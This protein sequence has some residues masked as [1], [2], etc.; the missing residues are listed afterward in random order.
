MLESQFAIWC[1]RIL[2]AVGAILLFGV[3]VIVHEFGHFLAGRLLGFKV[4]A[5]SVGFGPAIWRK[6]IN[7]VVYRVGCIPLGGY[8]AL[9]QLDPSE[10]DV[11]Q[12]K[13]AEGERQPAPPVAPWKRIV[14][15]VAGPF[16]NIVLAVIAAFVIYAFSTPDNFGGVGVTVGHVEPGSPAEAAGLRIGDTFQTINGNGVSC[17][18]EVTIECILGGGTNAL[19]QARVMRVEGEKTVSVDL[20]LP[21]VVTDKDTGY[22]EIPGVE[23]RMKCLVG[24]VNPGSPAESAGIRKGDQLLAVNGVDLNGPEDLIDRVKAAGETPIALFLRR[25]RTGATETISLTPRFDA[26]AARPLIGIVFAQSEAA[27]QPWMMYRRPSLQ[28][29]NDAKGIFRILRALFAPRV[30]GEAKRAAKGMGGAVTLFVIFWMQ[31]QAGILQTLAFLRYLCINLAVI[32]LLPLPV[33]DGGHVMFALVE[34]VTRR[35]PSAKLTGWIYNIFA[36]LLIALML[37]LLL[38]DVWNFNRIFRRRRAAITEEVST[39]NGERGTEDNRQT[40]KPSNRQTGGGTGN[41]ERGTEDNRQ[42]VKPSNRQTGGGTGNGERGT[43]ENRQT[44]KP[45]NRQTGLEPEALKP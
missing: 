19:L 23:P 20:E 39:G 24:S 22:A 38:R 34:M 16:G 25:Y 40:G 2:W 12:G 35:K 31:I 21:V 44:V 36:V 42:T 3:A 28:L 41:G 32:N 7:G 13:N 5:F 10:M 14:V 11:I 29:S 18:N 26:E 15:A 33:L 30:K 45:S 1:F 17:W 27:N 9:P 37:T 43:E 4:D 6:K 8:V